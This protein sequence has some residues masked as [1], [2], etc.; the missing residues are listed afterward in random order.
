MKI[1]FLFPRLD[2]SFKNFGGE[3]PK[4]PGEPNHPVRYFWN[5]FM[6]RIVPVLENAG[7]DVHVMIKPMWEITPE[8]VQGL[9]ED[10]DEVDRFD[11]FIV[12]HKERQNFNVWPTPVLY[13]MQMVYPWTFSIDPSGW[14]SSAFHWPI[15]PKYH[16]EHPRYEELSTLAGRNISK[17]DQP[18]LGNASSLPER[19]MLLPLQ[20]PHDE[21]IVLHS[22]VSMAQA[23]HATLGYS[24]VLDIPVVVKPHPINPSAM[25]D[26]KKV[27]D[28]FANTEYQFWVDDVSIHEC[29][30]NAESVFTVNSGVGM[31]AIM[32][33]KP[34]FS[35]GESEYDEVSHELRSYDSIVIEELY[36]DKNKYVP[37]Y[38][39]FIESWCEMHYSTKHPDTFD[40]LVALVSATRLLY[41]A[42]KR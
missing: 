36:E 15:S 22:S 4:V 23:L 29:L 19:F 41:K 10:R 35:F 21:N 17:F 2:I 20:L 16:E 42:V 38:K 30:E 8:F 5:D 9:N 26:M 25:V 18:N 3:V 11:L 1:G 31:E 40:K 39:D 27:F 12:P 33:N 32:H 7:H 37:Q 6:S 13:Y 28:F 34:V 14:L 24:T